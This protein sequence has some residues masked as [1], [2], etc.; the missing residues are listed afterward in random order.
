MPTVLEHA[1]HVQPRPHPISYD[2]GQE[3]SLDHW[4]EVYW[5]VEEDYLF[6]K[7]ADREPHAGA[8]AANN[9][10]AKSAARPHRSTLRR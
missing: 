3:H 6:A 7:D 1:P 4:L 8:T 9:R 10:P 5:L 2:C